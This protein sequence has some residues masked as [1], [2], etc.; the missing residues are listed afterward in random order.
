M[1]LQRGKENVLRAG[2][3]EVDPPVLLSE[4]GALS[5]SA[6]ALVIS[7]T[8]SSAIMACR[9]PCRSNWRECAARLELM[10]LEKPD[11]EDAFLV[12]IFKVLVENPQMT[13]TQ[14]LEIA[15]QKAVL[16]P[17]WAVSTQRISDRSSSAKSTSRR[18]RVCF[19]RCPGTREAG[20]Q[21]KI[22]YASPLARAMRAQ[23][24][25]AIQRTL[26]GLPDGNLGRQDRGVRDRRAGEHA[27][28]R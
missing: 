10:A 7:I 25:L 28:N 21:Y 20:A 14:V 4:D 23:D 6:C 5:P 16:A 27:R 12:T 26:R 13:A 15:Q 17:T 8:V 9:S 22:E 2:Q 1:T 19:R 11:I 24:A 18:R 3:K